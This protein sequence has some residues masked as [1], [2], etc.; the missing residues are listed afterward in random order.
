MNITLEN[1]YKKYGQQEVLKDVDLEINPSEFVCIVG[2]SGSGKTTLLKIIAGL[3][4]P[5]KGIVLTGD[6]AAM[7][8][9][10][11][12]LLP[13]LTVA[14]NIEFP[15]EVQGLKIPKQRIEQILAELDLKGFEKKYPKELSGGQ[16]QRVGIARAMAVKRKILLLD[17]PFSAL[18]VK[19]SEELH[20]LILGL[21]RGNK[22]TV[23][24]VSHSIEEAVFLSDRVIIM[25][26]GKIRREVTIDLKRPRQKT[27]PIFRKY[28]EHIQA[29][30]E[31]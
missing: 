5:T 18:D 28:V 17:E 29:I 24:M 14:Q 3:I 21:W 12:A 7:V 16:K 27:D 6:Q 26:Q 22:L 20:S 4:E 8:F 1:I 13:W 19:T 2:E 23:L 10:N 30:V 11:S 31:N 15:F 9:Q 25:D